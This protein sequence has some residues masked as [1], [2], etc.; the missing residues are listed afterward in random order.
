[1]KILT[2]SSPEETQKFGEK[3]ARELFCFKTRRA[4][5]LSLE[6][7]LGGGK[8]TFLKGLAK[9]MGISEVV[10]S[11]SF[12]IMKKYR[13]EKKKFKKSFFYH[14]DC[15]RIQKANE[16]L[17]IGWEKIIRNSLNIVAVEWGDQIKKI[18]PKDY[19]KMKFEFTGKSKRK[20]QL[21]KN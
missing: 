21:F 7:E 8:T 3:F 20:I 18:M 16:I 15:Y 4:I 10:K 1:M 6:G 13:I 9:G 5:V 12:V 11:P 2:A 17:D 14:L 19:I